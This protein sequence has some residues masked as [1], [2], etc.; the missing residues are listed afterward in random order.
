[1]RGAL[2]TL[3]AAALLPVLAPRPAYA[4]ELYVVE[5]LVVGLYSTPDVTG[6]RIATVKSGD[7][8]EVLERASDEVRVRTA[9]GRE[10]WIRAIYLQASPP[11]REQLAERNTELARLK[12]EV[13]RLE[14]ELQ[15]AHT[16]AASTAPAPPVAPSAPAAA[17]AEVASEPRGLFGD[18]SQ[19]APARRLWPWALSLALAALVLGFGLGVLTLDRHIRRKYGGLR[20][21]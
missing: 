7:R 4:E 11:L 2:T 20:I 12:D 6:E 15:A 3:A 21:Y 8:L 13:S 19:P 5:Q 17:P 14:K 18:G 9:G 16:S 1:M 10:G